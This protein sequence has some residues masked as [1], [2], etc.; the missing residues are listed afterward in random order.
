MNV[1]RLHQLL[2]GLFKDYTWEWI[3]S[4][5]KDIYGLEKSL[6]LRDERFSIIPCF[7]NICQFGD[8]LTCVKQ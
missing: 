4:F 1:D 2:K 8:K 6:D 5:L 7:S 3:V